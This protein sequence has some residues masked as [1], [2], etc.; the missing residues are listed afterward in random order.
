MSKTLPSQE[1]LNSILHYN[2]KTGD[3]VWRRREGFRPQWN[4]RYAGKPALSSLNHNGYRHGRID[5]CGYLAHRVVW[6]MVYGTDPDCVDHKNG[7]GLDN[8][9]EN[10]RLCN[11]SQN[12][13]NS[14]KQTNNKS[15]YKGVSQHKN[16]D[17]WQAQISVDRRVISI[18]YFN[19][20]EEAARAYDKAAKEKHGHFAVFNFPEEVEIF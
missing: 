20:P 17:K 19:T 11:K 6:K 16:S 18:G 5:D 10:L 2:P 3:I 8:R 14:G 1:Y 13:M 4:G 7:N 15:G 12:H 9:K